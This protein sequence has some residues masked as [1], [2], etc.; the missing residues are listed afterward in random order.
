MVRG[1]LPACL[2][3]GLSMSC[4]KDPARCPA[5]A[6]GG[7]SHRAESSLAGILEQ[8][9][10]QLARG[11]YGREVFQVGTLA[12]GRPVVCHSGPQRAARPSAILSCALFQADPKLP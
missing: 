6:E 7:V 10:S 12:N 1:C 3:H 9:A 8:V 2:P 4:E 11:S 5:W